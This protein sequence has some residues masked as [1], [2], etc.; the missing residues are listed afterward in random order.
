LSALQVIPINWP[1][2]ALR[3]A[4]ATGR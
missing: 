3:F 1:Y 2:T 4:R